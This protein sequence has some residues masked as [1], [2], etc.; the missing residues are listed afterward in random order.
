MALPFQDMDEKAS[1]VSIF[2]RL[3]S[4]SGCLSKGL[5]NCN[6]GKHWLLGYQQDPAQSPV[7]AAAAATS[8]RTSKLLSILNPQNEGPS[9]SLS[10]S[11]SP[12]RGRERELSVNPDHVQVHHGIP[13]YNPGFMSSASNGNSNSG[14]STMEC[15][16]I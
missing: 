5:L 9:L 6:R 1:M 13:F 3:E 15:L 4:I 2:I 16:H 7:T 14:S 10:G 8:S 12:F 11:S